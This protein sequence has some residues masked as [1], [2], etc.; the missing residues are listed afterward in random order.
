MPPRA[1]TTRTSWK[2]PRGCGEYDGILAQL[3]ADLETPPRMRGISGTGTD[4]TTLT[5]N[6]PA[7]A[8]NI[9]VGNNDSRPFQ[10]HPRG[11]GEYRGNTGVHRHTLETPPRMR[12]I[13]FYTSM[14]R[15]ARRNTP[16]D[17]G[18]MPLRLPLLA[19]F[20]KHPRGCGEYNTWTANT[21]LIEETPP[22]MRGICLQGLP[23]SLPDR[24]TPADAGNM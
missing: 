6:T 7:D 5:G 14:V 20:E 23:G 13:S 18:N 8:G 2:H 1:N 9:C 22:R 12:G 15:Y 10:K 19:I 11:C 21:N 24:N 4:N 16:A 17:A 3:Q